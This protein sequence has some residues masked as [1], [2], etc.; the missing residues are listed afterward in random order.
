MKID[1]HGVLEVVIRNL[2]LDVWN[3]DPKIH[4]F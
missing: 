2:E 3:S 1:T 4:F